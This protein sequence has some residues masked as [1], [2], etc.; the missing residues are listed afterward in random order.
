MSNKKFLAVFAVVTI[1]ASS[2]FVTECSVR[3]VRPE[4]KPAQPLLSSIE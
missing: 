3:E 1:L 4:M 2:V